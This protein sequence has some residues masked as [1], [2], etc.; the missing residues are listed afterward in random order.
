MAQH[1][2][3]GK[4]INFVPN[5]LFIGSQEAVKKIWSKIWVFHGSKVVEREKYSLLKQVVGT[6]KFYGN[7]RG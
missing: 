3:L 2:L 1:N 7:V 6:C 4:K 5:L